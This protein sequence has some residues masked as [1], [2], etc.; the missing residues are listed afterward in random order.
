MGRTKL[1]SQ[2]IRYWLSLAALSGTVLV[3]PAMAAPRETNSL[4]VGRCINMGNH[5][6]APTEGGWGGRK[7]AD[8]D[9]TIIAKA[10]FQTVRIPVRWSTHAS[11][12]SPFL[13]D[14]AYL[15]RIKHLVELADA[16]GL[17]VILNSHHFEEIHK[18]PIQNAPRLAGM[19]RQIAAELASVD[20]SRLWFEIEN[21]PHD[22]FND[23]NLL[24]TLMPAL[25]EIRKTNPSRPVIIGGQ[26][27]SGIDSLETLKL[28]N[29]SNI[30]PT[31]HYYDPFEFTHQG[32]EWV[33]PSPP[34]GRKFPTKADRKK[35]A[36][37]VKKITAY[38]ARTG[39]TPFMGEIGVNSTIPL[40]QRAAYLKTVR[41]AFDVTGIGICAWAYTNT[42]P[43][44][45]SANKQ[46]LPNMLD[47]M[48]TTPKK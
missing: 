35:L 36:A 48:G 30:V 3:Q 28:P 39:K 25:A 7:I 31:F 21:E 18:N 8:D 2:C 47:A 32:A 1:Y 46:W 13:I 26:N 40:D 42:M 43:L 33:D 45:D 14:P 41:S 15:D 17:N 29:D 9:F 12:T 4:P 16:A 6:E 22:N 27:W 38:I 11:Q 34:L 37:D 10:G 20:D 24:P 44:Y 23:S 19:W 5:L